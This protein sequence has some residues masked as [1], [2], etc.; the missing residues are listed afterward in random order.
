MPLLAEA[1]EEIHL[2]SERDFV[3]V[4]YC[5][6]EHP[7]RYS[8]KANKLLPEMDTDADSEPSPETNSYSSAEET[9]PHAPLSMAPTDDTHP[10]T[11]GNHAFPMAS[12]YPDTD[13][14][15]YS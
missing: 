5:C 3:V 10:H 6:R 7:S 2:F 4:T 15:P 1:Y 9:H 14:D 11:D 13:G 8:E 12:A